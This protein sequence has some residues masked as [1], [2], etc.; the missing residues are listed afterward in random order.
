MIGVGILAFNRPDYLRRLLMSLEAQT[1]LQDVDFHLYLDGAVNKWSDNRYAHQEN[2]DAC[3]AEFARSKL[4]NKWLYRHGHNVGVGVNSF[5]AIEG[6]TGSY[7]R[8]M[9]LEDDVVLSPHWLRLARILYGEL[10][11]HPD[12]F[13]F[14]PGFKRA[15]APW[16]ID[17]NLDR[18]ISRRFYMWCECFTAGRWARMRETY[19][20]FY[21]NL[22]RDRD[23][24]ERD[25]EAVQVWHVAQGVDEKVMSQ[26]AGR[27][28]ALRVNGMHRVQCAVNRALSIGRDGIHFT[29]EIFKDE[30]LASQTPFIFDSDATLEGWVWR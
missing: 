18:M 20:D 2:I 11:D 17:A 13:S 26:D 10:S 27:L 22:I 12:V 9:L 6:L 5:E 24:Y 29:P 21:D 8:V 16:E 14:S 25:L 28:T 4:S 23:Y 15:C 3:A 7:D 19:L 1:D 30:K